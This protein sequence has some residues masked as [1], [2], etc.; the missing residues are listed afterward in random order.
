MPQTEE[1]MPWHQQSCKSF[2]NTKLHEAYNFQK[3]VKITTP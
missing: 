1:E 2:G 3:F